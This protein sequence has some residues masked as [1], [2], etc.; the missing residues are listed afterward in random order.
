MFSFPANPP[1]IFEYVTMGSPYISSGEFHQIIV[2]VIDVDEPLLKKS[3]PPVLAEL[4]EMVL[5]IKNR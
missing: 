2:L 5:F 4:L 1:W 3:P